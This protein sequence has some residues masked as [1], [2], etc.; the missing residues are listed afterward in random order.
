VLYIRA[1]AHELLKFEPVYAV[2]GFVS[3]CLCV[4]AGMGSAQTGYCLISL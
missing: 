3:V 1:L 2:A 4:Y